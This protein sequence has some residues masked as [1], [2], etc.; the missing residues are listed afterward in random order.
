[1]RIRSMT[2]DD[3]ELHWGI[4]RDLADFG[5]KYGYTDEDR[6]ILSETELQ[7]TKI[8]FSAIF[9]LL[10]LSPLWV[11]N[12]NTVCENGDFQPLRDN[13]SQAASKIT[14][15]VDTCIINNRISLICCR[16]LLGAFIHVARLPLR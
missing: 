13:L 2:L 3:L 12:L 1:M 16:F 6:P 8:Y 11:Y 15:T 7:R 10:A 14:A 5:R 4:S 9:I